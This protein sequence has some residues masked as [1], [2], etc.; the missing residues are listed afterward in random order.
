MKSIAHSWFV[1]LKPR[2]DRALPHQMLA[3]THRETLFHIQAVDALC[4]HLMT[5][6]AQQRMQQPAI[7]IAGL[8]PRQLD[9]ILTQQRVAI[10]TRLVP[11]AGSLHSQQLSGRAL[12]QPVLR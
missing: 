5:A 1:L 7:A 11:V 3:P 2:L 8:L 4:V 6:T 10:R 12:T 9:Q